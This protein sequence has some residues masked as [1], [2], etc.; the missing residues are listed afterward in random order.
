[1]VVCRQWEVLPAAAFSIA[2]FAVLTKVVEEKPVVLL[3][4]DANEDPLL[5]VCCMIRSPYKKIPVYPL[6]AFRP[7]LV[8]GREKELRNTMKFY[9]T[10]FWL[11]RAILSVGERCFYSG[12]YIYHDQ[13]S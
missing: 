1:M 10:S 11:S 2:I 3:M 8:G 7:T 9:Q 5:C 13:K 6:P 12:N 4:I